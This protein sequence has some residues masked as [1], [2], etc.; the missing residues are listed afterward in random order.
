MSIK[1]KSKERILCNCPNGSRIEN[2]ELKISANPRAHRPDC[3]VRKRI[4]TEDI[5]IISDPESGYQTRLSASWR[6]D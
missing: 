4:I 3:K 6:L 1:A 5:W 2:N